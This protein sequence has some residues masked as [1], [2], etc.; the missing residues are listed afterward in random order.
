M[1][2]INSNQIIF[3]CRTMMW[4]TWILLAVVLPFMVHGEDSTSILDVIP[5]VSQTKSGLQF[6]LGDAD[7]AMETQKNFLKEGLGPSQ[8]RSVYHLVNGNPTE[9]LNI[10]KKFV[11]NLE[12]I[13]DGT[14]VIGHA[15]G[16]G[17]LLTGN[18]EHGWHAIKSATSSTGTIVG[19]FFGG[20][21]GAVAGHLVTDVLISGG[22]SAITG[23][24]KT[25]GLVDYV[26]NIDTLKTGEHLDTLSG[27]FFD[28]H[29]GKVVTNKKRK[30]PI[31]TE[32]AKLK[33]LPHDSVKDKLPVN[34]RIDIS[35]NRPIANENYKLKSISSDSVNDKQL[36]NIGM[37]APENRPLADIIESAGFSSIFIHSLEVNLKEYL[38][39]NKFMERFN[40]NLDVKAADAFVN[41]GKI[42]HYQ[43]S[44]YL[45]KLNIDDL[46]GKL[47]YLDD[48][49][50]ALI[51]R[52]DFKT[53][54]TMIQETNCVICSLAGVLKLEAE[55]LNN[56]FLKQHHLYDPSKGSSLFLCLNAIRK[57][58]LIEYKFSN[59][60]INI[61]EIH[62]FI[63]QN[64]MA[65]KDKHLILDARNQKR[66]IGHCMTMKFTMENNFP[67][68]LFIDYQ[69]FG[70]LLPDVP[71]PQRF[72][73]FINH[74]TYD[75]FTV[76]S[77][78]KLKSNIQLIKNMSPEES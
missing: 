39:Y 45:N 26:R 31:V 67:K 57:T 19:G 1:H 65:L 33:E 53:I 21:A 44:S 30:I 51:T 11:S 52:Y 47:E 23:E 35:K 24:V 20:P 55:I 10:Q 37:D 76:Y 48:N 72:K 16:I 7:G 50:K 63:K 58:G 32:G 15:K 40:N 70:L 75:L 13:V 43:E 12:P 36:M 25:H 64:F 49:L 56:N 41:S 8:V 78:E 60:F 4:K 59:Y 54:N 9:A 68:I 62:M 6:I 66:M 14:P 74:D 46:K 77:V 18:Q 42:L 17:H 69:K 5:L 71:N 3:C 2:I 29:G 34:T 22:E 61:H 28:V 73:S 38:A 27:L